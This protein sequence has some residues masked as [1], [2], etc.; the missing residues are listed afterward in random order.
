[1]S[2]FSPY[3]VLN[4]KQV[5]LAADGEY[6][7]LKTELLL[8]LEADGSDTLQLGDMKL[9]RNGII[10]FVSD[11]QIN[12][13]IHLDIFEDK[14]LLAFLESQ[15]LTLFRQ[16]DRLKTRLQSHKNEV[17]TIFF[18]KLNEHTYKLVSVP[19]GGNL[20][21]L[22][23]IL[24][25]VEYLDTYQVMRAY[26]RAYDYLKS[27]VDSIV[28]E[29]YSFF[30]SANSLK[31]RA[32]IR[33]AVSVLFHNQFNKLPAEF[34]P[35]QRKY[36]VWCNNIVVVEPCARKKNIS[37]YSKFIKGIIKDGAN[38]AKYHYN[39]DGNLEVAEQAGKTEASGVG[40]SMFI[41]LFLIIKLLSLIHI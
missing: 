34:K 36:G 33:D 16:G 19:S 18:D 37:S 5:A 38:I 12:Q 6:K 13:E 30:E 40:F 11:L 7:L 32:G 8:S 1:M 17:Q 25:F 35:I 27:E 26:G 22:N 41:I 4:E 15:D 3:N 2:Y 24:R 28:E 29:Y 9:D 20:V 39:F 31:P 14:P 23:T 21:K 10:E